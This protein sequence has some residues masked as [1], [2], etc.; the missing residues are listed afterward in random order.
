[1]N[2]NS[3]RSFLIQGLSQRSETH[4]FGLA[5]FVRV[6]SLCVSLLRDKRPLDDSDFRCKQHHLKVGGSTFE[7]AERLR[8]QQELTERVANHVQQIFGHEF[9]ATHATDPGSP[10]EEHAAM[11]NRDRVERNAAREIELSSVRE[12]H[13]TTIVRD[14]AERDA[15]H[16]I[17]LSAVREDFTAVINRDRAER[18]AAHAIELSSVREGFTAVINRDREE[19]SA[20]HANELSSVREEHAATVV[21]ER[22]ERSAAHAIELSSVREEHAAVINRERAERDAAHA[23]ELSSVREEHATTIVRDRAERDAAHGIELSAVREDFTAVINRDRAE[24]SAAHAIELS[25]VREGFTAVINRDREER[26]AAHANELSSVREEHAATVVRERAERS[27]AHAIELSSVREEHAAVINRERAERDAAHAIE[28][29]S[30]REEYVATV[31]RERAELNARDA[32]ELNSLRVEHAAT[33]EALRAARAALQE[34]SVERSVEAWTESTSASS[35][36]K[37]ELPV[38]AVHVA[39]RRNPSRLAAIVL[40]TSGMAG[41][42]R[43]QSGRALAVEGARA[44]SSSAEKEEAS[45]V[46]DDAAPVGGTLVGAERKGSQRDRWQQLDE[47]QLALAQRYGLPAEWRG[48]KDHTNLRFSNPRGVVFHSLREAQAFAVR[49]D[50]RF[51]G[52]EFEAQETEGRRLGDGWGLLNR[53]GT[54][55]GRSPSGLLFGGGLTAILAIAAPGQARGARRHRGR[56]PSATASVER[57]QS[58]SAPAA[59]TERLVSSDLDVDDEPLEAVVDD[60]PVETGAPVER[61]GEASQPDHGWQQLD[62]AQLA[63]ARRCGL[64]A[65][66]RGLKENSKCRFSSPS[67]V[68]LL[69][70]QA[71]QEFAASEPSGGYDATSEPSELEAQRAEGSRRLGEGWALVREQFRGNVYRSPSGLLFTSMRRA[72]AYQRQLSAENHPLVVADAQPCA[73]LHVGDCVE[74]PWHICGKTSRS[75]YSARVLSV[76]EDGSN[77]RRLSPSTKNRDRFALSRNTRLVCVFFSARRDTC[78]S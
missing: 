75:Y 38:G 47:A 9:N 5:R 25:S 42:K 33:V 29:S 15:A 65:E 76:G 18:S 70:L 6:G 32:T 48:L 56:P 68:V 10:R 46:T 55:V 49:Y 45:V 57:T 51:E 41:L 22:A 17:E 52:R 58:G 14:R 72:R 28:L 64:P 4:S 73:L 54:Y 59:D 62:E 7:L 61:A 74:A 35:G 78:V 34:R 44:S 24:R 60:A 8:N 71:A 31:V 23:I 50:A 67:G 21:R 37:D 53:S 26:S 39:R 30:V 63:Y 77:S 40:T 36:E 66:W 19:R 11:I 20:A 1:M 69:T 16:G 3:T 12:E 27:A 43:T 2:S 13:A